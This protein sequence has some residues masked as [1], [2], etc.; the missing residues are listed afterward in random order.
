[1]DGLT[2]D[3]VKLSDVRTTKLMEVEL[4]LVGEQACREA[5]PGAAIDDR[6]LCAGLLHGGKDSLSGRQ[7]RAS[8]GA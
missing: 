8:G 2:G 3:P 6:T 4:P 1:M 7:W 5:Y